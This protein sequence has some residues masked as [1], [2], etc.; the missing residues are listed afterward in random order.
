MPKVISVNLTYKLNNYRNRPM[1]M[2]DDDEYE[3]MGGE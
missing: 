2:P 1:K 3:G